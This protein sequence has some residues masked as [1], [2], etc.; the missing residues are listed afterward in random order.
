MPIV[1][2]NAV[3]WKQNSG[4]PTSRK[5]RS[6][7]APR[8]FPNYLFLLIVIII[9]CHFLVVHHPQVL[10]VPAASTATVL[11]NT[12]KVFKFGHERGIYY[13]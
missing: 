5:K 9:L 4:F 11:G 10:Y 13:E 2:P 8:N 7:L 1:S 6:I 12:K 3:W